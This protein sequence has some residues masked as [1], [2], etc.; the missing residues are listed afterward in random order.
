MIKIFKVISRKNGQ[1]EYLN[2]SNQVKYFKNND[3]SF[4]GMQK[5]SFGDR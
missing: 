4:T 2:E 5:E 1:N 3:C